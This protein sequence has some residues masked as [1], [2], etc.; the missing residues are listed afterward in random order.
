MYGTVARMQT[1]TG[2]LQALRDMEMRKP[3]GFIR[4]FVYQMDRDPD[5]WL[6]VVMFESKDAYLANAGSTEQD[7]EYRRLRA[8]LKGDPQWNDGAIIFDTLSAGN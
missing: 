8:Q 2:A 3:K 7:E 4:S 1:K 5:E 6:L